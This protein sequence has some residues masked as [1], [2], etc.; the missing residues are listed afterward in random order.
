MKEG[1]AGIITNLNDFKT[2]IS[3]NTTP[4]SQVSDLPEL[5]QVSPIEEE[6]IIEVPTAF[7]DTQPPLCELPYL[8]ELTVGELHSNKDLQIVR[9]K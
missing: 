6:K 1:I 2:S 8:N 4:L 9:S 7:G 3:Q 5:K